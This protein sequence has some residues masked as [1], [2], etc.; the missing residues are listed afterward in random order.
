MRALCVFI[1]SCAIMVQ[2]IAVAFN[3]NL[4]YNRGMPHTWDKESVREWYAISESQIPLRLD[5]LARF[6][7]VWTKSPREPRDS[8]EEYSVPA[9][10]PWKLS[11]RFGPRV[12]LIAVLMWLAG[13]VAWGFSCRKFLAGQF[14]DEEPV[15]TAN[16][17]AMENNA[18][19]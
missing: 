8:I 3:F 7:D 1:S 17:V 16:S 5:S 19:G 11:Q 18:C 13:W 15:T 2:M 4:E 14:N 9:F 6:G 12:W 10:L